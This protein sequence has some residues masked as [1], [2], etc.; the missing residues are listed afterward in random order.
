MEK[1]KHLGG[2]FV[3]Q[4]A[5]L[6]VA[7]IIVRILGFAYRLP[8]TNMIGD[9][10][11]GIYSAGYYLY[12]FFLVM[13]SAGLPV[14]ISKIISENLTLKRYKNAR[15]TFKVAMAVA[16][17]LGFICTLVMAIF[18]AQFCGLI[19]SPRSYYS[20]LT[21]APTVFVVSIMSVYRGYFQG[22]STTVPTA[23]S[24]IIEQIFNAFFS[25]YLA[26]VLLGYG[27]EFGAAG[28]TAGTGIGALSALIYLA[29]IYLKKRKAIYADFDYVGEDEKTDSFWQITFLIIR[30]ALPIIA[31]TAIFSMT[32]LIDMQMVNSRLAASGAFTSVE[33]E[34]LYGQLTGKYVTITTM[35]VSISTALATAVIPGIAANMLKKDFDALHSKIGTTLRLTMIISIP[36]AVGI[37]FLSK[38]ILEMLYPNYPEG[39]V[40]L[41]V[42]ALSVIFL[43]LSQ[44][45]TGI[46]QG[47]G[48]IHIPAINAFIGSVVK[49]PINYVLISIP[50]INVSGAV[51][52]T[53]VCYI[54]A[55]ALNL[56]ALYKATGFKFDFKGVLIKPTLA[57]IIMG[58]FCLLIYYGVYAIIPNNT[59]ACLT[60]VLFAMA[61]YGVSLALLRG[62][63]REDLVLMPKGGAIIKVLEKY[64][65][66]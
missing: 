16:G 47:I 20:I 5:I 61:V 52:S 28:G 23:V 29:L 58:G 2:S 32:N 44:I 21:L 53:T 15:K 18:A 65:L 1:T 35:P 26:W 34:E 46:L 4:A 60:A 8:L 55:S 36:A 31:G 56:Y 59:I 43:A 24:Q 45:A 48:K 49:I 9:E 33:I 27:V 39:G 54:I 57:S 13:S 38:Q 14:A 64:K 10:G 12:N 6:G 66:L 37:G 41:Q 17:T 19:E 40:L 42:G 22:F 25:V 30:T 50:E 63:K 7:G 62:F 51:V 11:N 3:K